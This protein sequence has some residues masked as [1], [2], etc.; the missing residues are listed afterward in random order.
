MRSCNKCQECCN[1]NLTIKELNVYPNNPCKFMCSIG[2]SAYNE[3]PQVCKSFNCLWLTDE[4]IPEKMYP[5]K[6]GVVMYTQKINNSLLYVTQE[7]WGK[8]NK[9]D[10][11]GVLEWYKSKSVNGVIVK[12]DKMIFAQYGNKVDFEKFLNTLDQV[13]KSLNV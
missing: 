6:S 11:E 7:F 3:R 13:S 4:S 1:G 10:E 12:N 8:L 5:K 2:C 9:E